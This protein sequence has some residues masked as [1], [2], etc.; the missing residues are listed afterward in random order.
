MR[1]P[2][3]GSTVSGDGT[4]DGSHDGSTRDGD[5]DEARLLSGRVTGLRSVR[6][7]KKRQTQDEVNPHH[8]LF[9]PLRRWWTAQE[10]SGRVL[11]SA[12]TSPLGAPHGNA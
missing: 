1:A 2:L 8:T 6:R 7:C 5:S 3:S 4:G 10:G 9:A 11:I 12:S